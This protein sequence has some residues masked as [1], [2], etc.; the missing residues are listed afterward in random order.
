MEPDERSCF[1]QSTCQWARKQVRQP[2]GIPIQRAGQG[3]AFVDRFDA[4]VISYTLKITLDLIYADASYH[5]LSSAAPCFFLISARHTYYSWLRR[6]DLTLK[7]LTPTPLLPP[8]QCT[9]EQ[10]DLRSADCGT[11]ST[12]GPPHPTTELISDN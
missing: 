9:P 2:R 7:L 8:Q 12:R 6:S 3:T 1:L 11:E 5:E 10:F 4:V